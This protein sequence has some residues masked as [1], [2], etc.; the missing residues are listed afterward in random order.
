MRNPL[1]RRPAHI[2][3]GEIDVLIAGAGAEELWVAHE[4]RRAGFAVRVLAQHGP[5]ARDSEGIEWN[6]PI[7]AL[8]FDGH[9]DRWRVRTAGEERYRPR[10]VVLTPPANLTGWHLIGLDGRKIEQVRDTSAFQ[11]IAVH[12]FPNLFFLTPPPLAEIAMP[13]TPI[14]ARTRYLRQCLEL[15]RRTSSTRIEARAATQH[16]FH[17]RLGAA[18]SPRPALRRPAPHHFD[19]TVAADREAAHEY[20]GPALLDAP[21]VE[22]LVTVTLNGHPDPIDGR[23]HWYGRITA[24]ADLPDPGRGGVFLTLPGGR[25]TAGRLQERDPWGHLRITGVGEPPFPLE[26]APA[27]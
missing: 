24:D 23:Y 1:R 14:E 15:L 9:T 26:S 19:L 20:S 18:R 17:R 10:I 21:G 22:L 25:P 8:E 6:A 16:E 12:G 13:P 5:T 3:G 11:G 2:S 27:H 7:D 4:L